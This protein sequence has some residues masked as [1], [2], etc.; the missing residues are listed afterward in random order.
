[1]EAPDWASF[2]PYSEIGTPTTSI[3]NP[4][5]IHV[6]VFVKIGAYAVIEAL[7]PER[8]V[9]VRIEDG[10]YIGHFTRITAVGEVVIGEEA[11]IADRVYISDTNH[12]YDDVTVP[13]KRQGLR[14]GRRVEICRGAWIGIGAVIVGNVR[15]GEN[16]VVG[17]NAV[18]RE[19]VPDRTVVAGNPAQV[20][21]QH[22]G[23]QWHWSQPRGPA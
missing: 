21:R 17:A 9:T 11:M 7:V 18:V 6:G 22:D 13:I 23:E 20:V 3:V 15:I 19:D 1:M 4:Q 12:V 10:A 2:G 16:A 8:G 5:G 14:D